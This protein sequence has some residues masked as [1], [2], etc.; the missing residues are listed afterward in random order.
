MKAVVATVMLAALSAASVAGLEKRQLSAN[1]L[2]RGCKEV[3][4]IF[5][6]GSTEPGNMG[7]IIGPAVCS[8]LKTRLAGRVACQGVGGGYKA[9]LQDNG[10][11]K[12]TSAA[13]TQEAVKVFQQAASKCP[14]AK[15][16]F[17]GYSQGGAVMH[18]AIQKLPASIKNRL[19]GGVLFGDTLNQRNRHA[20]PG[21]PPNRVKEYCAN[22]DGICERAFRGITSGHLSY[23]TNGMGNQAVGFLI[24]K[25]NS[26][27]NG[28]QAGGEVKGGKGAARGK[29]GKGR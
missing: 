27:G 26:G 28:G 13:A 22:G 4:F 8:G 11:P 20:I 19:L 1:D 24:S 29:G 3:I 17:G 2:Q 23:T 18:T 16:V 25:I 9:K 21:F 14:N 10:N 15:I 5:A 7:I 6:R 12:G